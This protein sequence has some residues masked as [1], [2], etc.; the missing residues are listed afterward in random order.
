[1]EPTAGYALAAAAALAAAVLPLPRRHRLRERVFWIGLALAMVLLGLNKQLDLQTALTDIT[2]CVA[3]AEGWYD[4]RAG[5]QR[6]AVAA[7]AAGALAVAALLLIWLAPILRRTA[8]PA[9]GFVL[10]MGFIVLRAMSFHKI[11]ALL[12]TPVLAT[13]AHRLIELAALALIVLGTVAAL[14]RRSAGKPDRLQ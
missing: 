10:L 13:R 11:D 8:V 3:I 9:L 6:G 2:R 5:L 4:R 7:V 14:L 12:G 1:M